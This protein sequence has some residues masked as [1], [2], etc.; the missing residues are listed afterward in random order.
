MKT[1]EKPAPAVAIAPNFADT[2]RGLVARVRPRKIV[3]T[4]SNG[5]GTTL[6][7][8]Q[9]L[10]DN[11]IT[12][13]DLYSIEAD[14]SAYPIACEHLAERSLCPHLLCGMALPRT[15]LPSDVRQQTPETTIDDLLGYVLRAFAG[16]PD[17]LLID[18]HSPS[19]F[20][21]LT[22]ALSL[23]R[24]RSYI[25]IKGMRQGAKCNCI[26]LMQHDARFQVLEL[27]SNEGFCLAQFDPA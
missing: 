24:S 4:G 2:L 5:L 19:A 27:S 18:A 10:V 26:S 17:L 25:A 8:C 13:D 15:H 20:A 7:L 1:L 11:A 23:I 16:K 12:L 21:E 22:Y 3:E 9:A 6:A 14:T